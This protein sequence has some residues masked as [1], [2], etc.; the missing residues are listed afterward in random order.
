MQKRANNAF[1]NTKKYPV[2]SSVIFVISA[3]RVPEI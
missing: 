2:L 3:S 1:R